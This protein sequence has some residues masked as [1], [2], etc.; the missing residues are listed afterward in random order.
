M[1]CQGIDASEAHHLLKGITVTSE[2]YL[3]PFATQNFLTPYG[4]QVSLVYSNVKSWF[5]R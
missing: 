5:T 4:I 2:S 1:V 3:D